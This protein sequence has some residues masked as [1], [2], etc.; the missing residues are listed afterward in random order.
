M[1]AQIQGMDLDYKPWG[2]LAG[3][4]AGDREAET[5]AA[6]LLALQE[7]Q[8]GNIVKQRDASFAQDEMNNQ[9]LRSGRI[10]GMIGDAQ[11]KTAAGLTAKG[12]QD[13]DMRSQ[14][15]EKLA[16]IPKAQVEE[17]LSKTHL[18]TQGLMA[19]AQSLGDGDTSNLNF[20]LKAQEMAP[21]LGMSP[22]ELQQL[23][24]NP[25]LLNSRIAQNQERLT[26]VPEVLREVYKKD[27]EYENQEI[28]HQGDRES[29]E[30]VAA[31][32]I[33]G[34]D[35]IEAAGITAGKY[36][37]SGRSGVSITTIFAKM[38][39]EARLG[40]VQKAL[41]T[42]IDPETNE[43]M[44]EVAKLGYQSMYEQDKR[45]VD[46]KNT[47]KGANKVDL[48]QAGV[49]ATPT[50]SVGGSTSSAPSSGGKKVWDGTKWVEKP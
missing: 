49:Q 10:Q 29:R 9:E 33:A 31:A 40:A 26:M 30:R 12:T 8:L 14:I 24:Q 42:G 25:K 13:A 32:E 6:N 20:T 16:K 7:S 17:A 22:Q 44:T 21:K 38:T 28:I 45:T 47:A 5:E 43:P 2:G 36:D 19:L 34:R 15:A 41:T 37:R 3:I 11:V 50:P 1:A 27:R 4:M 48:N 46:A 18:Q 23:L 39:P 35:A